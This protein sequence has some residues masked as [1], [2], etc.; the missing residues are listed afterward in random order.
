MLQNA[1]D[2]NGQPSKNWNSK[3]HTFTILTVARLVHWKGLRLAAKAFITF[4]NDFKHTKFLIVGEGPEYGYLNKLFQKYGVSDQVIFTGTL[5]KIEF[6]KILPVGDVFLYPS[7]H[8]GQA[9]VVLQAMIAGL[10]VVCLDCDAI[11]E[12]ISNNCG[13]R[14]KPESPNQ[15]VK[16]LASALGRLAKH[17]QLRRQMGENA[18]NR[19]KQTYSWNIKGDE[20]NHIYEKVI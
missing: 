5:S 16:E 7:F 14:I 6:L 20:I 2:A 12:M 15:V 11:G 4:N 10:P 8:H 9:T 18:V 13:I 3:S 19:I 17:P 1:I